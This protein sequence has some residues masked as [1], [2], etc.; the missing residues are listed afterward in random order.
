MIPTANDI[1]FVLHGC[2]IYTT[3]RYP[4]KRRRAGKLSGLHV[5]SGSRRPFFDG[6][7][8]RFARSLGTGG[9]SQVMRLCEGG[10][11]GCGILG[12]LA[13]KFEFE[14]VLSPTEIH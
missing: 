3:P 2:G 8:S 5:R 10:Y 4:G 9:Y 11:F 13:S 12:W 1:A 7:G 14:H 6:D